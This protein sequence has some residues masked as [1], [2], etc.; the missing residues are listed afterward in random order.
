MSFCLLCHTY[1]VFLLN[2]AA[3]IAFFFH[4]RKR[5][6]LFFC[7][8]AQTSDNVQRKGNRNSFNS[9]SL[10]TV[11]VLELKS[12][13]LTS[14][15]VETYR[16][17]PFTQMVISMGTVPSTFFLVLRTTKFTFIFKLLIIN[18]LD[19]RN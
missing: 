18:K 8:F 6:V 2:S 19:G 14:R 3:K 10:L 11:C 16:L 15:P 4:I 5:I 9:L 1:T 13:G 17:L 12:L 7:S